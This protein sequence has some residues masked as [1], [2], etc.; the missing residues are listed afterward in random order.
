MPPLRGLVDAEFVKEVSVEADLK[1][2]I[3]TLLCHAD[4]LPVPPARPKVSTSVIDLPSLK[5]S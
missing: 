4:A 3:S 1:V 2:L 5:M